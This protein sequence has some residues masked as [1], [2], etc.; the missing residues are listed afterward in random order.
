MGIVA[1]YPLDHDVKDYSGNGYHGTNNGVTFVSGKVNNAGDFENA[2]ND[3]MT[4]PDLKLFSSISY[5]VWIKLRS[6]PSVTGEEYNLTD[7]SDGT[8]RF[9]VFTASDKINVRITN[10]AGNSVT[11]IYDTAL[12]IDT[13]YHIVFVWDGTTQ[14]LYI[15]NNLVDSDNQNGTL[16]LS[17]LTRNNIGYFAIGSN[18]YDGQMDEFRIYDHVLSTEEITHLNNLPSKKYEVLVAGNHYFNA[19]ALDVQQSISDYTRSYNLEFKDSDRAKRDTITQHDEVLIDI[20]GTRVF[21]GLIELKKPTRSKKLELSGRDHSLRFQDIYATE[22]FSNTLS[23]SMVGTMLDNNYP[24]EFDRRSI[25][26]TI[27][28]RNKNWTAILFKNILQE[29]ADNED[30]I[31]YLDVVKRFIFRPENFVDS[32]VTFNDT[33]IIAEDFKESSSQVINSVLVVYGSNLDKFVRRRDH[34]SIATYKEKQKRWDRSDI[35]TVGEATEFADHLL[36][37]FANPF[38]VH[39]MTTRLSE[40]VDVGE[41]VTIN[42]TLAGYT[43][44]KFV[45]LQAKHTLTK[46]RSMFNIGIITENTADMLAEA[47]NKLRNVEQNQ[48]STSLTGSSVDDADETLEV[49][50][51]VTVE[52]A[53]ENSALAGNFLAGTRLAGDQQS[54]YTTIVNDQEAVIT[55]NAIETMMRTISQIATVPN[56]IDSSNGSISVGTGT[57]NSKITDLALDNEVARQG[58]ESSSPNAGSTGVVEFETLIDDGVVSS[59]SARELGIHNNLVATS[60]DLMARYLHST[61]ITKTINQVLRVTWKLTFTGPD[62]NVSTAGLNLIRDLISGLVYDYLDNSN[63]SIE[64]TNGSDTFRTGMD[65]GYPLF[66]TTLYN[67]LLYRITVANP[68]DYPTDTAFSIV[69]L[70][71]QTSGGVNAIESTIPDVTTRSGE[72]NII[73]QVLRLER[74]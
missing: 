19:L 25:E 51:S 54:G 2:N 70:Y 40:T 49:V 47:I 61:T 5:S 10:D 24:G 46:M 33:D 16:D 72:D 22:S 37:K 66:E 44:A 57:T 6:L 52:R 35:A 68:G 71:N 48:A 53:T 20:R 36:K 12:S 67:Q 60:G 29:L 34:N 62:G 13:W 59:I 64:V 1:Y 32:G 55:N 27:V 4:I 17:N 14:Y 41:I 56:A 30:F 42:S 65:S 23:S 18:H 58:L 3:Y 45:V 73:R 31:H 8:A 26:S 15:N 74:G 9:V 7:L 69:R 38:K 11:S 39:K 50:A 21:S 28:Q 43:N 63:T